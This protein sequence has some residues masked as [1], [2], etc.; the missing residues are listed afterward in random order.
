[1]HILPNRLLGCVGYHIDTVNN[2]TSGAD[3]MTLSVHPTENIIASTFPASS[4]IKFWN[5]SKFI[6]HAENETAELRLPKNQRKLL[7]TKLKGVKS[8]R[9]CLTDANERM[10][11]LEG[12][13][14][15]KQ[16]ILSSNDSENS[17]SHDDSSSDS[18]V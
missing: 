12:L 5:T 4:S 15:E 8:R 14:P 10:E 9:L 11:Y 13:L 2:D 6:E 3:C 16:S 18:D 7:S 17:I 1:M